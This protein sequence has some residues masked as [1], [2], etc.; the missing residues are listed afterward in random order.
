MS[1][2]K[3]P[4]GVGRNNQEKLGVEVESKTFYAKGAKLL[5]HSTPQ[6]VRNAFLV[7][8]EA[9][10]H[11]DGS[12]A[13]GDV[14]QAT[15]GLP[16]S[17]HRLNQEVVVKQPGDQVDRSGAQEDEGLVGEQDDQAQEKDDCRLGDH[18]HQVVDAETGHGRLV[19]EVALEGVV[20]QGP[21]RRA[22]ESDHG[23]GAEC[24]RTFLGRREA[25]QHNF[26]LRIGRQGDAG[27]SGHS[28]PAYYTLKAIK[29]QYY[30]GKSWRRQ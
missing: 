4:E 18:V 16:A 22:H 17:L 2:K 29:F 5:I 1:N 7:G 20:D 15:T 13:E 25:L 3:H 26:S 27:T 28:E 30:A 23:Q 8:D 10:E 11:E 12:D 19:G 9:H 24:D 14:G 6:L 21:G